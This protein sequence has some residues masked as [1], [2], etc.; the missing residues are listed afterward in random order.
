MNSNGRMRIPE[1]QVAGFINLVNEEEVQT[2]IEVSDAFYN[3][4][5]RVLAICWVTT[6]WSAASCLTDSWQNA[7]NTTKLIMCF[8]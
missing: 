7:F 8:K 4:F 1:S 5:Y 2:A 6:Q 3:Q